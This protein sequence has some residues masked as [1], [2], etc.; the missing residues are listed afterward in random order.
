M[1]VTRPRGKGARAGVTLVETLVA[2]AVF[3]IG[4]A[5]FAP[6]IVSTVR[7]NDAA[8]VRS[9]AVGFA[10]ERVEALRVEPFDAL[11][12]GSDVPAQGFDR[13]WGFLPPPS[14]AGDGGDLRRVFAT[15]SWSLPGRGSGTVTLV[16]S[17][18]RY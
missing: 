17:R 12:A 7:A 10:Q 11:A 6:L 13:R 16:V 1:G 5:S 3:A 15:V 18:A 4:V 14:L 8:A 2:L 9:Q